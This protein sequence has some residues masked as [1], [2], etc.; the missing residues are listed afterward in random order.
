MDVEGSTKKLI[1]TKCDEGKKSQKWN[2]AFVNETML[3]NWVEYGKPIKDLREI[4]DLK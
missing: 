4:E 3:R 2:W 1:A